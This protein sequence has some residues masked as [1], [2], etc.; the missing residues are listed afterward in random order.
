MTLNEVV[1]TAG[2][3]APTGDA[4]LDGLFGVDPSAVYFRFLYR[5]VQRA[6]PKLIVELGTWKGWSTAHLAAPDPECAV[7][8]VD[9]APQ[10]EFEAILPKYPNIVFIKG[11]TDDFEVLNQVDDGKA[12]ICYVDT[13]HEREYVSKEVAL[14]GR[15][16][17]RG[18]IILFDDVLMNDD[19]KRFWDWLPLE[20]V[21]LPGLH[22][23]G[24]GAALIP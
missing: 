2:D 15:K 14:W 18:G 17:R 22:W 16:V 19:M 1:D 8:T 4:F 11:R 12:D 13:I 7:I 20:K 5:L 21:L 24:F 6:R 9:I 10:R 3:T 23:T